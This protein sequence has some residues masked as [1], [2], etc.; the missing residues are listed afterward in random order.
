MKNVAKEEV[1]QKQI[2][3]MFRKPWLKASLEEATRSFNR[4]PKWKRELSM[5]FLEKGC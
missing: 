2:D 5:R 3:D 1:S 4:L